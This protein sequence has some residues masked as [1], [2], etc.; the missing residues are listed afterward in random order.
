MQVAKKDTNLTG[1][2][3]VNSYIEVT[4]TDI[5]AVEVCTLDSKQATHLLNCLIEGSSLRVIVKTSICTQVLVYQ[6][7][8]E[9]NAEGISILK[10]H[11]ALKADNIVCK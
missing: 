8:S 11:C 1:T 5:L 10:S 9:R 2:T 6:T 4:D 7:D 3:T